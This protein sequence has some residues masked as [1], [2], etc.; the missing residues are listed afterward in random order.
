MN[1]KV[2]CRNDPLLL[3]LASFAASLLAWDT[4]NRAFLKINAITTNKSVLQL[5]VNHKVSFLLLS[6][7]MGSML[8]CVHIPVYIVNMK[9]MSWN[10]S[11]LL[12]PNYLLL[13]LVV[14]GSGPQGPRSPSWGS[15]WP[16]GYLEI[17]SESPWYFLNQQSFI[18][19]LWL[20]TK[21]GYESPV[22]FMPSDFSSLF[23]SGPGLPSCIWN[24]CLTRLFLHWHPEPLVDPFFLHHFSKPWVLRHWYILYC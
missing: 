1:K 23:W 22:A 17:P 20:S 18:G 21:C 11:C 10:L 5:L 9:S 2:S 19:L 7:L 6:I 8:S 12:F 15:L 14:P 24:T 3:F 16:C 4:T 13:G